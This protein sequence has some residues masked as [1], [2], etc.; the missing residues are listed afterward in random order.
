MRSS[1]FAPAKVN[2]Y[3]HVGPLGAD[4]YHPLESWMAFADI[5]DTVVLETATTPAFVVDGPFAAGVPTD[6]SNLV[7][8][9]R[10]ALLGALPPSFGLRLEKRLPPASGIGGGSSDAAAVLRLLSAFAPDA[11]LPALALGLGA[12]VPACLH[13]RSILARGRGEVLSPAPEA[14]PLPAVLVNPGVAVSTGAIFGLYDKGAPAPLHTAGLGAAFATPGEV[15]RALDQ[16]RNDLQAPAIALEPVIGEVLDLL[17]A[18]PE[19]LL[20][21]MSGSGA[22]CFALCPSHDAA[23]ALAAQVSRDRPR[24]WVTACNLT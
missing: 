20:A 5:G 3:L 2:L 6:G 8:K 18:R 11:D 19:T 23:L 14:P 1:E 15:A 24:W 4:G 7:L 13:G 21:R 9:A 22:T 10:D 16:T 17:M 12:D